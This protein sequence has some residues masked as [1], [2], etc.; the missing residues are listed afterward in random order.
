MQT[1]FSFQVGFFLVNVSYDYDAAK[2]R[3][4]VEYWLSET[5]IPQ[6]DEQEFVPI[7]VH[8][9]KNGQDWVLGQYEEDSNI[10]KPYSNAYSDHIRDYM[11]LTGDRFTDKE[12]F[13][14]LSPFSFDNVEGYYTYDT[15]K[16]IFNVS[17][18]EIPAIA[19]DDTDYVETEMIIKKLDG[20]WKIGYP[21][22]NNGIKP[23]NNTE[24][25][26]ILNYIIDKH[27]H[28]DEIVFVL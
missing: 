10:F 19:G 17:F 8:L 22:Q 18:S 13:K 21:L 16:E 26:H 5:N 11:I 1:N 27:L 4:D 6:L 25:D 23:E 12:K 28:N 7:K 2:N 15:E 14:V 20:E 9:V 24:A 3:Y